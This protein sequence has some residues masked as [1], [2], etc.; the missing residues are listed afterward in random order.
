MSFVI[1]AVVLLPLLVSS[2]FI[3]FFLRVYPPLLVGICFVFLDS[4]RQNLHVISHVCCA[5]YS[6]RVIKAFKFIIIAQT[7]VPCYFF[8]LTKIFIWSTGLLFRFY[9]E[10]LLLSFFGWPC[11]LLG[12][13]AILLDFSV[14]IP[15]LILTFFDLFFFNH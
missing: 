14:N 7:R 8:L 4:I 9:L 13:I 3:K 6:V 10:L 5:W 15:C 12:R 1:F 2:I 11:I